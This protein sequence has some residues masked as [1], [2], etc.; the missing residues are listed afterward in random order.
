VVFTLEDNGAGFSLEGGLPPKQT[1]GGFGLSSM[2]EGVEFSGGTF[3]I[4]SA[5]GQGTR[6]RASWKIS[7]APNCTA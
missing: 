2:Q 4:K 5:P 3:E 6:I 7:P 1:G